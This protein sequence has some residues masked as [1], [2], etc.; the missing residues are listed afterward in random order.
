MSRLTLCA[1]AGSRTSQL[2]QNNIYFWEILFSAIT[3]FWPSFS[4]AVK[5]SFFVGVGKRSPDPII[6]RCS[7]NELFRCST[8]AEIANPPLSDKVNV[9]SR[10]YTHPTGLVSLPEFKHSTL[11][12]TACPTCP[13]WEPVEQDHMALK[14]SWLLLSWPMCG[15]QHCTIFC[16]TPVSHHSHR[17]TMG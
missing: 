2:P 7:L 5:F 14:I 16:L 17:L 15:T 10:H 9:P 1:D 8:E 4:A 13:Q 12:P 11:M 6:R 3:S